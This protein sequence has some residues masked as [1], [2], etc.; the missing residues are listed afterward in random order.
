[1]SVIAIWSCSPASPAVD[2]AAAAAS[3]GAWRDSRVTARVRASMPYG[4]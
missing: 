3:E 4:K 2:A 1:L